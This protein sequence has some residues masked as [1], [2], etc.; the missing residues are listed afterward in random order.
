MC[1][2][3]ASKQTIDY[4]A[5][6]PALASLDSRQEQLRQ[7][8]AAAHASRGSSCSSH[9]ESFA[10]TADPLPLDSDGNPM[11]IA[12]FYVENCGEMQFTPD[13]G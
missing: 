12:E 7:L 2:L 4:D 5:P 6:A 10:F 8:T 11:N 9:A 3:A 1:V 13:F